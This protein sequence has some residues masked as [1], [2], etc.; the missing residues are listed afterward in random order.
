MNSFP[1]LISLLFNTAHFGEV[2]ASLKLVIAL[3]PLLL[4]TSL[5]FPSIIKLKQTL[6]SDH[7]HTEKEKVLYQHYYPP[8]VL[9]D[10]KQ[11][12]Y[13]TIWDFLRNI[14]NSSYTVKCTAIPVVVIPQEW[15][16]FSWIKW[17]CMVPKNLHWKVYDAFVSFTLWACH[18]GGLSACRNKLN[19]NSSWNCTYFPED[20]FRNVNV[21]W[22]HVINHL[23]VKRNT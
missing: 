12:L 5:F 21:F 18:D 13:Y 8:D 19:M 2:C 23:L 4:I 1:H 15:N 6:K 9:L 14:F 17:Y 16:C 10:T 20:I 22:M 3:H 11:R 7:K